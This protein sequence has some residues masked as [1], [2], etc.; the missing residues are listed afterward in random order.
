MVVPGHINLDKIGE[1]V[2]AGVRLA[3]G[4]PAGIPDHRRFATAFATE[5]SGRS[6]PWAAG[7]L[8]ADA[9]EVM[10]VAHA[11]DGS[12]FRTQLR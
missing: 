11:F 1:A 12:G 3:G 5:P 4:N 8:I 6:I 9:V 7:E 2:K 10:A